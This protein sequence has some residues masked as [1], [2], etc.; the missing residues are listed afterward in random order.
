MRE[1]WGERDTVDRR[2]WEHRLR[3]DSAR[4]LWVRGRRG[5]LDIVKLQS[6]MNLLQGFMDGEESEGNGG[7]CFAGWRWLLTLIAIFIW[8][9]V[10]EQ[11]VNFGRKYRLLK[12]KLF[13]LDSS[14]SLT[15]SWRVLS[16]NCLVTFYIDS[17]WMQARSRWKTKQ[18]ISEPFVQELPK[19]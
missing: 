2:L 4:I 17:I 10:R 9:G 7:R 12:D 13:H 1:E 8:F 14:Y 6:L 5:G 15:N 3:N 18:T 11:I 19:F 16:K